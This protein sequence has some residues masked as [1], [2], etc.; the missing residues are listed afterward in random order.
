MKPKLRRILLVVVSAGIALVAT[1][2]A[3]PHDSNEAKDLLTFQTHGPWS[4]RV[5]LNADD[6]I[7]YG[8]NSS[9]PQR[10]DAWR[11]HGY[12]T[13]VMT[14]VAWGQYQDYLLGRFDGKNH[15]DEEQTQKSG[16][17]ISHGGNVFYMSP[18]ENYGEYL[19]RGVRQA[20]DAGA[21]SFY[22]EE[23]E[24]WVAGGW[25]RGFRR[26]WKSYYHEDW[27]PPDSSP[28]AQ[29]RASK[30]KYF[31]YRRALGQVFESVRQYG[32]QHHRKIPCYVPTHSL[33]NY[34]HWR[35]VSPESSLLEVGCD[36][37]IGQVWT[38]TARTPNVYEGQFKER[39]FET[40]YLE[41]GAMQNL[42]RASGR[43]VWYLND[44]VEDNPSH[45]WADY[46]ANW[47]STLTASLLQPEVWRYEIM[48]WP[49][50]VFSGRYPSGDPAD[51]HRRVGIPADYAT[52]LQTV[53]TALGQMKQPED[54]VKWE[55]AGLR[56]V[57]VLVSDTMMF[58]RGEPNPS[59]E[60]LG[61]FY[62]LAMPLL[63]HGV[64]VDPVQIEN[65]TEPHF[66]DRYKLLLLTYE[67]QKP[68]KPDFHRALAD[69][70]KAG[71]ALLVIDN[72]QDPYNAVREWW[73]TPPL[74]DRTP[75]E[76][77][78][79][80][81]GLTPDARGLSRV[82]KGAVLYEPLSPAA[83][84]YAPDGSA[85][86]RDFAR[87]AAEAIGLT[88]SES[89]VLVLRRGPYIVAAGLDESLTNAQPTILHGKLISLFDSSLS[90]LSEYKI[91][92]GSRVLL[93]DLAKLP[94]GKEGVI[95]AASRVRDETTTPE[96]I[97]FRAD[98]IEQTQA[99]LRIRI[100]KPPSAV[101]LKGVTAAH[102]QYDYTDGTLRLHFTNS[103][104]GKEVE[105]I[106]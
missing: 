71:G 31:L 29:Y 30:L 63:K 51:P 101:K 95:A 58:Q 48:P 64:P 12:R 26:E 81:L 74:H 94:A 57:G 56:G 34:A 77:L 82:G 33:L 36:G 61:S 99:V 76:H 65:A 16:E 103:A 1:A 9:L 20:L 106:R 37:Y 47:E 3:Q 60:H 73:N 75:R 104:D 43:L 68:P 22:L 67:G 17:P 86:V 11:K 54:E 88:W 66:L 92:P 38:G 18:S 14:G 24:F 45:T 79:A 25:S 28:D 49:Q 91:E 15:E 96:H 42:V 10:M 52:E 78:F 70:V 105:I 80:A 59:D 90:V 72:D 13:D 4:P 50:R 85:K 7:V 35:I 97:Q 2:S 8:I 87:Q 27:Q 53:I 62:G 84:S 40:A 44:P 46:R 55:S 41:Y 93:L 23:P 69:W 98:G 6:A 100:R 19:A 39:T 83:L 32:Q 21:Q 102:D 89:N 5:Q